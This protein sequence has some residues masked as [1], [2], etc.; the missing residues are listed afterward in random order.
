MRRKYIVAID[1]GGTNLKVA[2]ID[3]Q[4]KIKDKEI[5]STKSFLEK[6]ELILGI[7]HSINRVII[8]IS[9]V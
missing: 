8:K 2:L 6:E 9:R 5:I 1:L 7:I 3:L 4:Y